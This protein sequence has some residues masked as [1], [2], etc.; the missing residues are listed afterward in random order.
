MLIR[1]FQG[2]TQGFYTIHSCFGGVNQD[3]LASGSEGKLRV[4]VILFFVC[5]LLRNDLSS[6]WSFQLPCCLAD[7]KVY[8]WHS[9]RE[10]PITVL[11]GHSRTVNCVHWN[12][13]LPSMLASASDDGTV[14]IW[15]PMEDCPST[16]NSSSSSSNSGKARLLGEKEFLQKQ[17]SR[18]VR[19]SGM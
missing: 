7:H 1:K 14:R 17:K 10:M 15:G 13:K 8:I 2:V 16:V 3:F 4:R 5:V 19:Y 18:W 9:K 6:I 11:E 12:P